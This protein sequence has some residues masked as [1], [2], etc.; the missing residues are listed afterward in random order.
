MK[1]IDSHVHI[2]RN[3]QTGMLAQGGK[4][5]AGFTGALDEMM[6]MVE[7][8]GADRIIAV[9]VMPI[10]PMRQA[11]M[12]K[13]P[14]D[15]TPTRREEKRAALEEKLRSRLTGFN[16][17]LLDAARGD[18]RITPVIAA[19]P[20]MD[21]SF[22]ADHISSAIERDGLRAV[23]I[24]PAVNN[25]HPTDKGYY[26]IFELAQARGLT[27]VSHGGLSGEDLAGNYCTPD[28]FKTI[29]TD[30]PNLK[31]VV[32]HLCHP[33]VEG[34]VPVVHACPNLYT[35]LSFVINPAHRSFD[36]AALVHTI[37][38]FGSDR[39]LY[40]TDYPWADPIKSAERFRGL[41]LADDERDRIGWQN[42]CGLFGD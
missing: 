25:V 11:A 6:P 35:D 12:A 2:Y 32:A 38:R 24:H 27:V 19:D 31:L 33:H 7:Q 34:L 29:C 42:S 13:W 41:P 1:L 3:A 15:I 37:R 17:W 4:A 36:D 10:M 30:F 40:G 18:D 8:G 39:V 26:P 16:Q 23:K 5:M 20:S 22:M 21:A 14:R 9:I 28:H